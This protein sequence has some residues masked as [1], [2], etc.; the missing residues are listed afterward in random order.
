[1]VKTKRD[2]ISHIIVNYILKNKSKIF[3]LCLE[4]GLLSIQLIN[5]LH[6]IQQLV[7]RIGRRLEVGGRKEFRT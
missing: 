3:T 7:P 6:N 1:M 5:K 2:A 4:V